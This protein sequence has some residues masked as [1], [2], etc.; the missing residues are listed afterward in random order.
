MKNRHTSPTPD[1]LELFDG[2]SRDI[3]NPQEV[4]TASELENLQAIQESLFLLFLYTNQSTNDP[5]DGI[6]LL[7]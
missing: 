2:G 3:L 5:G 1:Y 6:A 7:S 4:F